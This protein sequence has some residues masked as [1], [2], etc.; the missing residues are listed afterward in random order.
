MVALALAVASVASADDPSTW[1]EFSPAHGRFAIRMPGTPTESVAE[2]GVHNFQL[3]DG[4]R[5]YVASFVDLPPELR[6]MTT[7]Q[8]LEQTRE[9]FVRILP[10]SR[11]VSSVS[12][13]IGGFPGITCVVE[14][15]APGRPAFRL[16][17]SAVV[18]KARLYSF[19]FIARK[20]VFVESEV[21]KYLATFSLR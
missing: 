18:A 11:L 3:T 2:R 20:E 5:S 10:G 19:G 7:N 1:K 12:A 4:D 15:Q 21:D 8:I 6:S 13:Q 17:M 9:G 14:A 16:K